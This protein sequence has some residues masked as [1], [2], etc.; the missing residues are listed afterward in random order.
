[1][2]NYCGSNKRTFSWQDDEVKYT[3]CSFK[4]PSWFHVVNTIHMANR[5]SSADKSTIYTPYEW[6]IPSSYKPIHWPVQFQKWDYEIYEKE[7][8]DIINI[9]RMNPCTSRTKGLLQFAEW[10]ETWEGKC[11]KLSRR[12]CYISSSWIV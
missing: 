10:L 8:R 4:E 12:V 11:F 3:R 7:F 1:M 9:I 6:I 2:G 5:P